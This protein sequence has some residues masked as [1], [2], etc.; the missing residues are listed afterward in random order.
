MYR[1]NAP[2]YERVFQYAPNA[3]PENRPWESAKDPLAS[4]E[5]AAE[6]MNRSPKFTPFAVSTRQFTG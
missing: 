3:R 6:A 5:L 1:Q 4:V 2:Q